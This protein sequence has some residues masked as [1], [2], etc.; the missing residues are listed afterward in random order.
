MKLRLGELFSLLRDA[1]NAFNQ[2]NAPRLAAAIAYYAISSIGPIL[3]LIITFAGIIFRGQDTDQITL[4]ITDVIQ[5]T[6]GSNTDPKTAANL[7]D[8]VGTLVKGLNEQFKNNRANALA[9]FTGLATLFLTSTGLFLQ[10]QGALNTLWDVKPKPG[11][12]EI[13]RTRLIGFLMVIVFGALVVAYVAVN[14]YLS[15]LTKQLGDAVGQGANF[16]RVGSALLAMLFFTPVFAATYKWLPAIDLKWRQVWIGGAVTAVL[17]VLSQAGIGIY[18]ARTTPGSVYGAASTLFIV[19]LWIYFSSMVVFFGAE[20]TW[21][22]SQRPGEKQEIA[23][24]EGQ[25]SVDKAAA[26]G[27]QPSTPEPLPHPAPLR[28]APMRPPKVSSAI[29]NALLA[30]LALPAVLVLGVLRV[31]GVLRGRR[32]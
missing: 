11:F 23:A 20:V 6:L 32:R 8:F 4:K 21:V 16:A 27:L 1:V 24:E 15:A 29:G 26:L 17:F 12:F 22:Y 18:F 25:G 13:V 9:I 14:A 19:L 30:V 10:L 7:N 28:P 31:F 5:N 2:D 3:F